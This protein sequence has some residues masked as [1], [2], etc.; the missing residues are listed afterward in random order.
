M[1]FQILFRHNPST[2]NDERYFRLKECF[3][4]ATGTVRNRLVVSFALF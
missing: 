4:D 3:R 2:G 1:Y